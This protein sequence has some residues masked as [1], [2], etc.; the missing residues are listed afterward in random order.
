MQQ[1]DNLQWLTPE[2]RHH[3]AQEIAAR[4]AKYGRDPQTREQAAAHEAGHAILAAAWGW[5]FDGAKIWSER[6]RWHG[7]TTFHHRLV[8][9]SFVLEDEPGM[10]FAI[11]SQMAAG[12]LGEM[13]AGFN[14]E[15]SSVDEEQVALSACLEL[16]AVQQLPTGTTWMIAGATVTDCLKRN[17]QVFDCIR[18]HFARKKSLSAF[19]G[20]RLLAKVERLTPQ[21]KENPLVA[22]RA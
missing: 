1:V 10:V 17:G 18:S 15:A 12:R 13:L 4:I 2:G 7:S 8:G 3:V 14:Y 19:D 20:R 11:A 16:D 21:E 6:G 9:R 22:Q 5:R